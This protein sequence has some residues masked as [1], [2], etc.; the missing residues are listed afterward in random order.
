MNEQVQG[1]ITKQSKVQPAEHKIDRLAIE[2][3]EAEGMNQ[4]SLPP[5]SNLQLFLYDLRLNMNHLSAKLSQ[6]KNKIAIMGVVGISTALVVRFLK[7]R[8]TTAAFVGASV[9]MMVG[10]YLGQTVNSAAQ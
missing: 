6:H 9:G 5:V 3:S 8:N 1:L 10:I 4:V 7:T 2:R